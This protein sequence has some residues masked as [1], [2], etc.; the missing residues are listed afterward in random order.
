MDLLAL[1]IEQNTA[2]LCVGE[3]VVTT[4]WLSFQR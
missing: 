4:R 2:K 1:M 3:E